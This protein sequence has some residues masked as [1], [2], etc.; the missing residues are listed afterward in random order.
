[1]L[2]LSTLLFLLCCTATRTVHSAQSATRRAITP[3]AEWPLVLS[4]L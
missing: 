3:L 1:M 2:T 4:P